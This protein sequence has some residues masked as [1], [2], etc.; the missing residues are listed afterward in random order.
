MLKK[1]YK[2]KFKSNIDVKDNNSR[3]IVLS[4]DI[5]S[6]SVADIIESILDI[7]TLDDEFEGDLQDYYREPIKLVVNSFGGSVYDGFALI[8]AIEHSKTPIH[9]YC[10]GS[11]MSMGFIIYISTHVRF[12][13]KTSTLM[14]HEISDVFWGNITGAKQNI[15]ECERI[16]KVYDDYVLSR[17]KI[18]VAKMN[19]YKARKDDW[20][21]SAQE[22]LKYKIID[23]IL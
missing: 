20:Y 16:Q 13:H 12:A 2:K 7:N 9:G 15:K 5:T 22:G 23:K 1:S 21:M 10:Y 8:A 11:A 14:Y 19:D 6:S 4:S 18:P 17:T 3:N